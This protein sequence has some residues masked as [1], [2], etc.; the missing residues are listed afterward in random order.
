MIVDEQPNLARMWDYHQGGDHAGTADR[1]LAEA[2]TAAC[3]EVPEV[4]RSN[5]AFR[6]RVVRH[7]LGLGIRQFLDVGS[8]LP[9]AHNLHQLAGGSR[10]V[11]VDIDPMAVLHNRIGVVGN[12]DVTVVQA[13]L[14][15]P[16]L[17]L[18]HRD[19]RH[20]IDFGAP[21]A[22][23]A[24]AVYHFVPDA[25]EP[26]R[27]IAAIYDH[28]APGSY[29]AIS[30]CSADYAPDRVARVAALYAGARIPLRPRGRAEIAALFDRFALVGPGLVAA[31]AWSPEAP[32]AAP[33]PAGW[34]AGLGRKTGP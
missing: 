30:H 15:D 22:V 13:D 20:Y 33:E 16:E 10:V 25:E 32:P 17:V 19:V 5:R 31:R 27:G 14:R 28:V 1:R 12:P 21:V 24:L 6:D 2:V 7:L 26:A 34:Y 4:A 3:P 18:R 23:L 9:T 29:L 8:G 11:Y